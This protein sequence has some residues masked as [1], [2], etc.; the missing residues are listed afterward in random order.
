MIN[1]I[2]QVNETLGFD[3]AEYIAK[4]ANDRDHPSCS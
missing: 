4:P 2:P 3:R 1:T